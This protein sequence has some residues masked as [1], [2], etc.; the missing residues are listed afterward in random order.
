MQKTT[1]FL[2]LKK[3]RKLFRLLSPNNFSGAE[4]VSLKG[5]LNPSMNKVVLDQVNLLIRKD[6]RVVLLRI[7][8]WQNHPSKNQSTER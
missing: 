6:D 1:K 7:T 8:D 4:A 3:E 2:S 5:V